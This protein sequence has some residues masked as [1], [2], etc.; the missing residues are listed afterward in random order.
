MNV[1]FWK[2]TLAAFVVVV[3]I[4]AIAQLGGISSIFPYFIPRNLSS[5][6]IFGL[7][8]T[9]IFVSVYFLCEFLEKLARAQN[10]KP[11]RH[12][13]Q[14]G[15]MVGLGQSVWLFV[16]PITVADIL[17]LTMLFLIANAISFAA[18]GWVYQ[19]MDPG[20]VVRG[21]DNKRYLQGRKR[22]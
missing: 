2:G 6:I 11:F 19:R 22:R 18:A 20:P 15:I 3:I 13:A 10:K 12:G 8:L 5:W 17:F 1:R 7:L 14:L 9:F 21:E 4:E 16:F